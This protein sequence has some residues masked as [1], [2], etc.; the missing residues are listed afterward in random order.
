L[1]PAKI[2]LLPFFRQ[3]NLHGWG[4]LAFLLERV[5]QYDQVMAAKE[6]KEPESY[7]SDI[8]SDFPNIVGIDQ[9]VK[10]I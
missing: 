7:F 3:L 1:P 5:G 8:N 4:F 9:F 2:F 10:I 6:T